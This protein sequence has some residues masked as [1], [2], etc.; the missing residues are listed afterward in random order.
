MEFI[1]SWFSFVVVW[2]FTYCCRGHDCVSGADTALRVLNVLLL[3][4]LL[5]L[6]AVQAGKLTSRCSHQQQWWCGDS[7]HL[8][9]Q[10]KRLLVCCKVFVGSVATI[11]MGLY[12]IKWCVMQ[13]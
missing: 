10:L 11:C 6:L 1:A 2:R 5:L 3:L 13:C 7:I 8:V 4:L 12:L 9:W